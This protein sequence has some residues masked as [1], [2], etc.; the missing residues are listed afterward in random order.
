[1]KWLVP[2]VFLSGTFFPLLAQAQERLQDNIVVVLDASGSMNGPMPGSRQNK[3]AAAKEALWEVMQDVPPTTNVGLLVFS[4]RNSRQLGAW[5]YPLGP[6]NRSQLR[7]AIYAPQPGGGTPLGQYLKIGAD[8]LLEQRQKQ[9]GYG[10]YRLLVVTDGQASDS[11]LV[12]Q[13]LP[14]ILARGITVDVIGVAMNSNHQLATQV[15]SYRNANDP[16]SLQ[17]AV[18][19]V[20]AEVSSSGDDSASEEDFALLASLPDG[21]A[22]QMLDTLASSGNHPIGTQASP[23]MSSP[24]VPSPVASTVPQKSQPRRIFTPRPSSGPK[25]TFFSTV[26]TILGTFCIIMFVLLGGGIAGAVL[27]MNQHQGRRYR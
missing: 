27:L 20:F 9:H 15:H 3:M 19:S 2:I 26:A 10:S 25:M 22:E 4:H 8:K 14:D 17:Q 7:Y 1:M 24:S 12:R 21:A 11:Y 16:Q 18:S 23:T 13:Y 6:A 5:P